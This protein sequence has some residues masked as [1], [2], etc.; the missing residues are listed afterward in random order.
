MNKKGFT[1]LEVL[2]FVTLLTIVFVGLAYLATYSIKNTIVSQHKVLATH[3]GEELQEWLRGEKEAGWEPFVGKAGNPTALIYC[4]NTLPADI[5]GLT[6]GSGCG[7]S[8][9]LNSLFKRELRM[10]RDD[11][12]TQVTVFITTSWLEGNNVLQVP[13]NTVLAVWE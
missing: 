10:T 7:S 3:Y 5:S 13:I 1:L 11:D 4:V 8:Y 12:S 6:A 9:A 2:I